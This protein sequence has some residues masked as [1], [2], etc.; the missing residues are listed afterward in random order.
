MHKPLRLLLLLLAAACSN[1]TPFATTVGIL[2]AGS[3]LTV[4][5]AAGTVNAFHPASGQPP[6]RF[7]IAATARKGAA[8]PAAPRLRPVAGGV[9]VT[10]PDPLAELLVRVPEGVT[11][12]VEA[13][14]GDVHVTDITGN[15]R[16]AT[17]TGDVDVML[18][19]YAQARTGRGNV[20]IRMGSVDWPGTLH[21]ATGRGDVEVWIRD[22]ASF[23]A[24]L[25]TDSGMIFT[26]FNLRGTSQGGAET[27]DG[28][29][30]GGGGHG[31]EIDTCAGA[32]R[33]LQLHPQP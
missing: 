8:Q 4:R 2:P 17:G 26:D 22:K 16:I 25:H 20:S 19:G 23:H 14:A 21:I 5:T 3:T 24:H 28:D 33:L 1:Q 12:A 15:A 11:L 30:N 18:P 7:T 9:D 6:D 10:A 13:R 31:V 32:I 27:I 29:V